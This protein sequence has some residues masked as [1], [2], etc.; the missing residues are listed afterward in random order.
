MFEGGRRPDQ[1]WAREWDGQW[2]LLTFDI[3]RKAAKARHRFW[4]W[5]RENHFGRLQ[6]SVWVSPDPVS[7]IESV[8]KQAGFEPSNVLVFTGSATAGLGPRQ[9]ASKAWAFADINECHRRY[10]EFAE[11]MA[12]RIR[13]EP[14]SFIRLGEILEQD[15]HLW[16]CSMRLDPLLPKTLLPRPYEG[17][18]AWKARKNSI[19]PS[20]AVYSS[21]TGGSP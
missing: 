4:R 20:P 16:W 1:A 10:R 17:L 8:A 2:R 13:G 15:H 7:L 12:G 11:N 9:I 14:L 19:K 6:G 3:P 5:L 21:D 18:R